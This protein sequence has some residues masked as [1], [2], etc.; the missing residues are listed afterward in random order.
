[1]HTKNTLQTYLIILGTII[2]IRVSWSLITIRQI[3]MLHT[4][5]KRYLTE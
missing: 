4:I 5:R 3:C 2:H 1:M